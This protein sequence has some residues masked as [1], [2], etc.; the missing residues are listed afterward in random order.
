MIKRSQLYIRRNIAFVGRDSEK[1]NNTLMLREI[2]TQ[3][4]F[5]LDSYNEL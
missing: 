5:Q 4:V 2:G 1:Q 3:F